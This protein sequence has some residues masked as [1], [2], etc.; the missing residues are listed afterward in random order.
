MKVLHKNTKDKKHTMTVLHR[1][2]KDHKKKDEGIVKTQC[3][4]L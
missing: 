4:N 1:K 2:I 3:S